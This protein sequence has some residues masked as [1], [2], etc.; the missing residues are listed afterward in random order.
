MIIL[1][2]NNKI[3][4]ENNRVL[5]FGSPY[6]LI[7]SGLVLHLDASNILS[8]PTTG[9]TWYDL[10]DNNYDASIDGATYTISSGGVFD[11]NG[12]SNQVAIANNADIRLSTTTS[13]TMQIWINFDALT[14]DSAIINKIS[15]SYIFDGYYLRVLSDGSL[16]AATNGGSINQ[17]ST[18]SA[19]VVSAN[20]WY[21]LTFQAAIN[22]TSGSKMVY[23]NTTNVLNTQHGTDT[24]SESNTLRLG[25]SDTGVAGAYLNGKIGAFYFY[26]R[27]LS[28]TEIENNFNAT[29][30]RYGL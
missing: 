4:E 2:F 20:T 16:A 15:S 21:L 24:Y 11:L 7:T 1:G 23:V 10:T 17:L 8:Y 13:K 5:C 28:P 14:N 18:T 27:K 9:T 26:N 22:N 12:S 19:N 3:I 25:A 30:S 6:S 29:K